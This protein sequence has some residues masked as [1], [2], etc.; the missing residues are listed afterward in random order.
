MDWTQR[1]SPYGTPPKIR[2]L[3]TVAVKL[4]KCQSLTGLI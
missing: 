2:L 4:R 3:A 1:P